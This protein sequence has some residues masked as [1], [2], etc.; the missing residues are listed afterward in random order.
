MSSSSSDFSVSE[1]LKLIRALWDSL[2]DS[3][4]VPILGWH[5]QELGK[6]LAEADANPKAAIPWEVVRARL[7]G[8]R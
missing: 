1:R 3:T 7:R 6:R 4:D 8:E 2:P 5:W